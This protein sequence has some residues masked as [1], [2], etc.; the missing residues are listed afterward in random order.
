[1]I[2]FDSSTLILLAKV[3][4]LDDFLNDYKGEVII[5]YEVKEECCGRKNSFD[6][7]LIGKRVEEKK[8]KTG[9][10][11]NVELCEKF[12]KD[13][14]IS[15]GEAEALVLFIEKKAETKAKLFAADD[16]NAIK[17]SKILMIPFTSALAILARL[18]EKGAIDNANAKV[19]IGM[20]ARYGRYKESMI[21]EA[22]ER[23]HISEEE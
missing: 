11:H 15:K 9:K 8:I 4:I 20:L 6:A 1:M 16:K 22:K 17:A 18:V 21:K 23:L 5:P 19:K 3:E 10:I 13:F 7:L 12:V 2:V 14:S